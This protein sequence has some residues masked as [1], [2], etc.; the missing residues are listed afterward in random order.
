MSVSKRRARA[1]SDAVDAPPSKISKTADTADADFMDLFTVEVKVP[2]A[3]KASRNDYHPPTS[4]QRKIHS[5]FTG[6][7][8][9][10]LTKE[11]QQEIFGSSRGDLPEQSGHVADPQS[12]HMTESK[13]YVP[14]LR[15]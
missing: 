12:N 11:E 1:L 9:S 14:L 15:V 8:M 10:P 5:I 3:S 2:S 7:S 6:G 13:K 4:A